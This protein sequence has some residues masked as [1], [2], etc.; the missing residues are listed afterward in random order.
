MTLL[1]P[2]E[3]LDTASLQ[4]RVFENAEALNSISR[5]PLFGVGLGNS[6]RNITTLQGE[7]DGWF[8]GRSLVAGEVSRFTRYVHSSYLWIPVKM[9]IPALV[10]F[11][12]F[13]AALLFAG[14]RLMRKLPAQQM[15]GIVLAVVTGFAGLLVWTAFHQH[16]I[17][18]RSSTAVAAMAGLVAGIY[19]LHSSEHGASLF[20]VAYPGQQESAHDARGQ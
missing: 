12:W 6:Y 3:T 15:K 17:M 7:A 5:H 14:W 13:C 19:S 16:L 1:T 11:L 20:G 2:N 9:G 10:I 4:W 8:T 18:N